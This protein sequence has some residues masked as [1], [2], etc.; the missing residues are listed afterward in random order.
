MPSILGSHAF[1]RA[2]VYIYIYMLL[3]C[4]IIIEY[5]IE[6]PQKKKNIELNLSSNFKPCEILFWAQNLESNST[7]QKIDS[8]W[9]VYLFSFWTRLQLIEFSFSDCFVDFTPRNTYMVN[10]CPSR[11][12]NTDGE[13]TCQ[14]FETFCHASNSIIY[15]LACY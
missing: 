15:S 8:I 11:W 2:H 12:I 4:C 3:V 9:S 5:N 6:F 14:S 1:A 13:P 7:S 10:T